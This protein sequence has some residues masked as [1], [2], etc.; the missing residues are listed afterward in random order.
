MTAIA[1]PLEIAPARID[2][3]AA[4]FRRVAVG[5]VIAAPILR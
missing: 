2:S 5:S 1:G 3:A 4:V